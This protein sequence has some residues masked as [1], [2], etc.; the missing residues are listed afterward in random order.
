MRFDPS[1]KAR[2]NASHL[3]RFSGDSLFDKVARTACEAEVLPRKEL[4]E[5]WEVARRVRRRLRGRKIVDLASGHGLV[6]ILLLVLDDS[7]PGALCV[8]ER[9]PPSAAR[10]LEVFERQ[11]PRLV[12]RIEHRQATLESVALGQQTLVVS[13]HACGTLTDRVLDLAVEARAPVAVLPCCH[14]VAACDTGGLTGWMDPALAIDTTRAMRL[15]QAGFEVHTQTIPAAITPMNRLLVGVP[16]V[17]P[18]GLRQP[19]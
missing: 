5:S 18:A 3:A 2:L 19:S 12:G 7:S 1:N 10:L 8:D 14:D 16:G 6:A 17:P 13:A 15:R 11:W 9:L 4:Y